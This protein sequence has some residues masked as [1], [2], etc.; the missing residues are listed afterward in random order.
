MYEARRTSGE[1]PVP[2]ARVRRTIA[3]IGR[4]LVTLGLLILL[5]VTYELWGTGIF[6]ARE[7]AARLPQADRIELHGRMAEGSAAG[8]PVIELALRLVSA[9]APELHAFMTRPV[10]AEISAT[11]RGLAD[12]SPKPWPVRFR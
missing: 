7:K 10:D 11:L 3:A 9:T 5:F 6:T 1:T 2:S 8:N 12:F 4:T